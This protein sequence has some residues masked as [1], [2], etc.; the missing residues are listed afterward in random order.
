M[1]CEA[2]TDGVLV[3]HEHL[4]NGSET[5]AELLKQ[6]CCLKSLEA[7]W[8]AIGQRPTAGERTSVARVARRPLDWS[9][10]CLG[11]NGNERRCRMDE[12]RSVPGMPMLHIGSIVISKRASLCLT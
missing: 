8:M 6:D 2:T 11:R 9:Q 5:D 12:A 3:D 1:P 7:V 4:S 10:T